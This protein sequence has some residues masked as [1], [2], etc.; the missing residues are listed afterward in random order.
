MLQS[1]WTSEWGPHHTSIFFT[2]FPFYCGISAG[3]SRNIIHRSPH[4][5]AVRQRKRCFETRQ[6]TEFENISGHADVTAEAMSSHTRGGCGDQ[7]DVAAPDPCCSTHKM[8]RG[9]RRCCGTWIISYEA[10]FITSAIIAMLLSFVDNLF[11]ILDLVNWFRPIIVN[12]LP[13]SVNKQINDLEAETVG[14]E[15]WPLFRPNSVNQSVSN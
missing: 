5:Q 6:E 15:S 10:E 4:I 8:L 1:G 13:S 12:R 2:V 11:S 14:N 3:V 9:M 7:L